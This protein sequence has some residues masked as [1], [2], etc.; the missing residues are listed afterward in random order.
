MSSLIKKIAPIALGIAAPYAAP[1]L[2]ISG[3]AAGIGA[4]AL[5][6]A[7]GGGGLKGALLGGATGGIGSYAS[8]ALGGAT[9]AASGY[10]VGGKLGATL[11]GLKAASTV[12]PSFAS[13]LGSALKNSL[14]GNTGTTLLSGLQSYSAQD[15][16][17]KKLREAQGM[18]QEALSPYLQAGR[19]GISSLQ[20]GF[21]PSQ[22]ESD[23]GY[24]FRLEQGNQALDRRLNA[25][26]MNDSGAALKAAQ[27]YGQ[28]L[29]SQ[30]YND[31]YNQWYQ[32]NAALGNYGQGAA[33]TLTGVYDNIGNIGSNAAVAKSNIITGSLSNLLRGG[34]DSYVDASG[35]QNYGQ[36]IVGYDPKTGKPIYGIN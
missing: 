25:S 13:G 19:Q 9:G 31:A 3:L 24:Q 29:A 7:I 20:A 6:G 23:A 22:L 1:F 36:T 28:G 33:N 4:G 32:K 15:D 18:S 17:E 11:D 8:T 10:G 27:D 5:G 26:G 34:N 21:D 14:G 16:A 30:S 35:K 2:G 12:Q